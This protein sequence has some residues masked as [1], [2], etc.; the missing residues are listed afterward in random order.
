[1][2]LSILEKEKSIFEWMKNV[3]DKK[4]NRRMKLSILEN[5]GRL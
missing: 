5:E 3:F 4:K 2:K 1:M